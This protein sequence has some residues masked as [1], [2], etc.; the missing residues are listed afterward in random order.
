MIKFIDFLPTFEGISKSEKNR[1]ENLEKN[2]RTRETVEVVDEIRFKIGFRSVYLSGVK[3]SWIWKSICDF[4][5]LKILINQ[6]ITLDWVFLRFLKTEDW[7]SQWVFDL[8][9][10]LDWARLRA[11]IVSILR[12]MCKEDIIYMINIF[13]IY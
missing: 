10:A 2:K 7:R 13:N 8:V 6:K 11:V 4:L 3:P 9:I 5:Q 1:I 12:S